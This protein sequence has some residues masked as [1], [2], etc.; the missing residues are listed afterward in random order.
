MYCRCNKI[1]V[2]LGKRSQGCR[3]RRIQVLARSKILVSFF[4]IFLLG[5]SL[6]IFLGIL[7]ETVKEQQNAL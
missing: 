4:Y 3:L 5:I 2:A 1:T 7:V 6:F